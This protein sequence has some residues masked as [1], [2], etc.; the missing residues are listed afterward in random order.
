MWGERA[1]SC[2]IVDEKIDPSVEKIV[3]DFL[4]R[5]SKQ[6]LPRDIVKFDSFPRGPAGKVVMSEIKALYALRAGR[7]DSEA[8]S[9]NT[10][11]GAR[12][13]SLAAKI[14]RCQPEQLN[15]ASEAETVAGWTSLSHVELMLA[16]EEGFGFELSSREI[17]KF[18]TLGDAIEIVQKRLAA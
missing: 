14:L 6:K 13:Y 5:A 16:I 4:E 7:D 11:V 12:I 18:R 2:V 17:M 1:V 15:H 10:D 8:D 9:G 3:A